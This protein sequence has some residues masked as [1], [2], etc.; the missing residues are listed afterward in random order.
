LLAE[1]EALRATRA[2]EAAELADIVAALNPLIEEARTH[3]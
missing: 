2:T 3:A 1:L